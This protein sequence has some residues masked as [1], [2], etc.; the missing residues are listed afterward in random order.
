M[1]EVKALILA[2]G[3]GTR[4]GKLTKD[5]PK[6]LM[7]IGKKPLLEYWLET[8]DSAGISKVL[9]NLR[10]TMPKWCKSSWIDHVLRIG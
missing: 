6:C 10:T 1:K 2:A 8:L 9:V 7:P 4:L 3:N 5:W